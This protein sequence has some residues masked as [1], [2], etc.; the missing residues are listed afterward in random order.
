VFLSLLFINYPTY[1][2]AI[3]GLYSMLMTLNTSFL[4][5]CY[6]PGPVSSLTSCG[7]K[8]VLSARVEGADSI[9]NA[10]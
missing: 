1:N 4:E 10:I 9:D 6:P 8:C 7:C 2:S 3:E 5:H